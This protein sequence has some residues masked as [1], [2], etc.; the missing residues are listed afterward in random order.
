[1]DMQNLDI[2]IGFP[3][4]KVL[5]GKEEIESGAIP[6]G[7]IIFCMFR[8]AYSEIEPT[9]NEM[10]KWIEDNGFKPIGTAYEHYYN[11]PE[12]P[13]SEMLTMIVMPIL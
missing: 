8:G 11:G 3:V 2:E 13:E 7:K 12:F 6:A 10:S 1:M 5:P 9:Y 4:S